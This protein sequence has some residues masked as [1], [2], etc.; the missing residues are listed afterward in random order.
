MHSGSCILAVTNAATAE[1]NRICTNQFCGS[2]IICYSAD[3]VYDLEDNCRYPVEFLDNL[4]VP[5]VPDHCLVLKRGMPV[6]LLR[7]LSPK[8]GLC[9]GV[10]LI[11]QEVIHGR[12]VVVKFANDPCSETRLI[13][14]IN[15]IVNETAGVPLKWRRRQFPLRQA[16][17]LTINKVQGQTLSRAGVWLEVPVFSHGQLY[18]AASRI[19]N[20]SSIRFFISSDSNL[21]DTCTTENI[22]FQ[23]VL[24]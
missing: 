9:N 6:I 13:P 1:I 21:K 23:E 3:S 12:I 2:S 7:N 5:G 10:R 11:V 24:D 22:V 15:L 19:N 8:A 4:S 14:R 18:T 16:F 17:S 20:P